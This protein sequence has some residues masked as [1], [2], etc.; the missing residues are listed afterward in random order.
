VIELGAICIRDENS[1]VQCR[2]KIRILA[3]DLNFGSVESTRLA[4]ASSEICRNLLQNE[5]PSSVEVCFDKVDGRFGLL[6]VFHGLTDQFKLGSFEFLFDQFAITSENQELN[7]IRTFKYFRDPSFTPSKDF[8]EVEKNKISQLS[9]EELMGELKDAMKQAESATQ[10]KSDFL[11]NMSHEIRTPMNAIIGMSILALKTELTPKQHNYVSK[12]QASGNSLLGIINDILDFSKIEAGKLDMEDIDFRL[13]DVL[14]NLSTLVTLKAQEK[15]LEVL[16]SFDKSI[17]RSLV[18]DPLRLGQVLVNLTNNSV[19]FTEQGEI[20]VSIKPLNI[21][22]DKVELQFSVKDTGIGLTQEQIGR[23]FKEFSQADTS[24]T[25]KFGGTGLGLTI[26]KRLVEMMN[27]KIWV[28]SEP[29]KGSSFIFTGVFGVKNKQDGTELILSEDLLGKKVLAVD[30]NDSAR[31]IL[32]NALQSFSLDTS[33]ASS[34]FEAISKV[35]AAD[36]DCPYDL[37]IMDWQM[38]EMNGI[39]TSEIIK[40]NSKLKKIPKIIMLTPY[41]RE[42]VVRKA[43]EVGID[44]FLVKPMNPSALLESIMEVF[45]KKHPKKKYKADSK[46]ELGEQG[47]GAIRGAAVLLA[48]D[49]EINQEIAVELLEDEGLIVTVANNGR[50]AVELAG[51]SEYDC[52]LMDMQMPEM[53][54]YEATRTLRKDIQFKNLPIIAMTANAMAGDRE[55]CLEAGMNDHVSKPINTKELFGTLIKWIPE[56]RKGEVKSIDQTISSKQSEESDDSIPLDLTGLDVKAGLEIVSGKEKLYRKLLTKFERDYSNFTETIKQ[57]W[58]NDSLELAEREAHTIKGVAGNIGAKSIYKSAGKIETAIRN[59]DNTEKD[60]LLS[61]FDQDLTQVLE[62]LKG[63]N[64][65]IPES[66]ENF[67]LPNIDIPDELFSSLKEAA[68]EG[69]FDEMLESLVALSKIEPSGSILAT[70]YR[71]FLREFKFDEILDSLEKLSAMDSEVTD[72]EFL[73]KSLLNLEPHVKS[74]KPKKCKQALIEVMELNWPSEFSS[75]INCIEEFLGKYKY[76]EALIAL[77][78][79]VEKIG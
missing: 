12:I 31:E 47:M 39:K 51:K 59:G 69:L 36:R 62:S 60:Q 40:K 2:N 78:E 34:G 11:A 28:E 10:A 45:L 35:V 71:G 70:H 15:G 61:Q 73:L 4:T 72:K 68:H 14:D 55:K 50:E 22:S 46:V 48:E 65:V 21:E 30:D 37:V 49:N 26:S 19:K 18:G 38:P 5:D 24:T 41:G 75:E 58:D 16:F 33:M 8:I 32:E 1:I 77:E 66:L 76:K 13:D 20:I 3:M 74:R 53:D 56:Q 17:P 64:L 29:G 25:R 9:R 52:I 6:L 44:G 42:E 63:L 67:E 54:G 7:K 43:E 57:A 23:L 79:L 27:G